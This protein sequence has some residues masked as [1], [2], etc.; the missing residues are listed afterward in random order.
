LESS[1]PNLVVL[2][3]SEIVNGVNISVLDTLGLKD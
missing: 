2:S 3:Y 1:F